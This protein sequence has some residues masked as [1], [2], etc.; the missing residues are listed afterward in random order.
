MKNYQ[1]QL[2]KRSRQAEE[3]GGNQS[4]IPVWIKLW[5]WF[6]ATAM[7]YS[8]CMLLGAGISFP[9]R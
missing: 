4:K 5:K 6:H 1:M 8:F 9:F 7:I 3:I 2:A